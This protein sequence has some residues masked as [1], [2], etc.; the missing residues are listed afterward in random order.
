MRPYRAMLAALLALVICCGC[1]RLGETVWRP[2]VVT[3]ISVTG[4]SRGMELER[5][6]TSETVLRQL[7]YRLN[8]ISRRTP[9]AR[10]SALPDTFRIRFTLHFSD[11]SREDLILIGTA[12]L[13]D[14]SHGW[15]KVSPERLQGLFQYLLVTASDA[16]PEERPRLRGR[17]S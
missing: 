1:S 14:I 2:R 15:Q 17:F 16:Q 3:Q 8:H 9:M 11:G 7:L 6:Y 12:C 10:G 13:W 4:R 5:F